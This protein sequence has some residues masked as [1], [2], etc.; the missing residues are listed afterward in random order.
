MFMRYILALNLSPVVVSWKQESPVACIRD[1]ETKKI[2]YSISSQVKFLQ[3]R[4]RFYVFRWMLAFT[5]LSISGN[6]AWKLGIPVES[7]NIHARVVELS[8]H[9]LDN[10][11]DPRFD[12]QLM[13]ICY[14]VFIHG[15]MRIK[16]N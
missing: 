8:I 16:K 3:G 4:S 5:S 12:N 9:I 7:K 6:S 2:L 10:A 15:V 1:I 14:F 11:N 13:N